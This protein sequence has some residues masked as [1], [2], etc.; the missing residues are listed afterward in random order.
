[1]LRDF[2]D[3]KRRWRFTRLMPVVLFLS[4]AVAMLSIGGSE[5]EGA[6]NLSALSSSAS[7]ISGEYPHRLYLP[8][9]ETP[10]WQSPF[11]VEYWTSRPLTYPEMVSHIDALNPAWMRFNGRIS[12]R[13][14]QPNEGD[15]IQWEQIASFEEELR[16]LK[17]LGVKPLVII[18]DYPHW[19]TINDPFP[20]SCGAIRADKFEAFAQFVREL[21]ARYKVPEFDV[22]HWQLGNEPDVDPALVPPDYH[23]GCW[24]DSQDIYYGGRHY[25]EMVKVIGPA[26]KA[27]DPSAT[28]WLGGLLL[29]TH[30]TQ[31]SDPGK[32]EMFMKGILE[33]GAASY[34]DMVAYHAYAAY[35]TEEQIDHELVGTWGEWGGYVIGKARFLRQVMDEYGVDKPLFVT[36]ISLMCRESQPLCEQ[37]SEQ[38]YQAQANHAVRTIVRGLAEGIQGY[39][40]YSI[41]DNGWR[42]TALLRRNEIKPVYVAYQ[43]LIQQLHYTE[44][45]EPVWYGGGVEAYSFRRVLSGMNEQVHV[46]WTRDDETIP[47]L[48]P[49]SNFVRA[50]DRDG[51]IITPSVSG[52]AYRLLAQFEPIYVVVRSP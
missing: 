50:M 14:L 34:F 19:A 24:G 1:M 8:V 52:D 36:E 44:Y 33:S 38:F 31:T 16:T 4:I 3:L 17:R 42:Y 9:L 7:S 20:T 26:I 51:N 11:G 2:L 23:L 30:D 15:P 39:I 21:V 18:S 10:D 35:D 5:A 48:V 22:H 25:G 46:V 41:N 40:W 28:V 13:D 49:Q 27:E 37:P 12:W 45:A 47:I 43:E 32:P 6:T 29:Y